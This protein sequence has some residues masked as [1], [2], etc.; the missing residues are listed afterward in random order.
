VQLSGATKSVNRQLAATARALAGVKGYVTNL[1]ACPD[2]T[3]ITAEFVIGADHRLIEVE[4]SFRMSKHDL[5]A[6]PIYHHKRDS[7]EAHLSIVFAALA[8]SRWIEQTTVACGRRCRRIGVP[9]GEE[10]PQCPRPG[11]AVARPTRPDPVPAAPASSAP[12]PHAGR[13]LPLPRR[14]RERRD[15]HS[16]VNGFVP[17]ILTAKRNSPRT[18]Q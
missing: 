10:G 5:H 18:G 9:P 14:F 8:V 15:P 1:A 4:K 6:R 16:A 12:H 7:I 17:P 3:P 13:Q 11:P 2:G